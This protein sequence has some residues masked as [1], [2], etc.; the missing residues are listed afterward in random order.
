VELVL[1]FDAARDGSL[2]GLAED[3]RSFDF[4]G[5]EFTLPERPGDEGEVY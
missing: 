3:N 2:R 5:F 4:Q 1:D